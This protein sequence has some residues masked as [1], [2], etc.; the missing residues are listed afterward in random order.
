MAAVG[1][2]YAKAFYDASPDNL[3]ND[4]NVLMEV[5]NV[6]ESDKS[7]YNFFISPS[8]QTAKKK[9]LLSE[10]FSGSES[11][12]LKNFLSL[13]IDNNKIKYLSDIIN[14]CVR[15]NEQNKNIKKIT[16][17]SKE[18]PNADLMQKIKEKYA[19]SEAEEIKTEIIY[20]KSI[21]G[22]ISIENGGKRID[23]TLNLK[24][25]LLKEYLINN[26]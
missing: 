6:F 19:L 23:G 18:R 3:A 15:L 1:I 10:A 12:N 2:K 14:E 11:V 16:I 25:R 8:V 7:I 24:L 21:L 20:D 22:G 4:L 17:R 13:L 26:S 5:H 9:E